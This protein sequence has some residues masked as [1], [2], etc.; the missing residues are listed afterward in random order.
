MERE[1]IAANHELWNENEI[2]M[3]VSG[4]QDLST[5]VHLINGKTINHFNQ[6][7]STY[8]LATKEEL[9]ASFT[10]LINDM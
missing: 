3:L 7:S 1:Q 2:T 9:N 4:F 5:K 10:G 8:P 6:L